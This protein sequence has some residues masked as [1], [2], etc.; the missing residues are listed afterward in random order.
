MSKAVAQNLIGPSIRK[1]RYQRGMTQAMLTAR[2]NRAGWDIGENT[3]A[4][5]EAQI[6]CVTD[7]EIV[8]LAKALGV[9]VQD[10]F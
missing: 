4:K 3:I 5:I 9:K 2:C 1:L 10:F 7:R 8:H 6:R